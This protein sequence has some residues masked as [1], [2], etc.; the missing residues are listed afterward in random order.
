MSEKV[1]VLIY[2]AG[3]VV[4]AVHAGDF[5]QVLVFDR[6]DA[7]EDAQYAPNFGPPDPWTDE[8]EE[9][10]NDA[11][12]QDDKT[13]PTHNALSAIPALPPIP[14]ENWREIAD[15]YAQ[16]KWGLEA[17]EIT[18]GGDERRLRAAYE[19]AENPMDFVDYYAAKY[20]LTTIDEWSFSR[21]KLFC[22]RYGVILPEGPPPNSLCP[23]P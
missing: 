18:D 2:V 8:C 16:E 22:A 12:R 3:G 13:A 23:R 7:R 9:K 15:A 6:D 19:R 14:W 4:Q 21:A 1:R 11:S 10:W 20:D 5:V 17:A